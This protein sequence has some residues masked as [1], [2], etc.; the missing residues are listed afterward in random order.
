MLRHIAILALIVTTACAT[1]LPQPAAAAFETRATSAYLYD[2]T[3]DT[4]LFEKNADVPLPPASM[5]KLM[6]LY[7]LFD[8][9]RDGRVTLDT[10]FGVS[11][12]ARLMGGS[13][14]FLDE[15]DRPT[16]ESLIKGIIVQSGNDACIVVAE[17][18]A[19]SEDA[20]ARQMNARGPEIGL[21][22]STF[23]NASGWPDPNHR[24]SMHDLAVLASRLITDFPE[25][26]GYFALE[27]YD[28]DGRSPSN[29]FNRN[30]VLGLDMGADG[31]K[32]GHTMEAGY[33]LVGS[34]MQGDR[35][36][37]FVFSGL[38]T[39]AER[40]Q[41]AESF[42]NWGFRQFLSRDVAKKGDTITQAPVW[43]GSQ[44]QINLITESDIRLLVP[45]IGQDTLET[46]VEYATPL[47][48]PIAAGTKVGELVITARDMP[49]KRIDLVS[50]R[51]VAYGG[52]IPRI[53]ASAN[54]LFDKAMGQVQTLME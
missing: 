45:A 30:P 42:I 27:E 28:F 24:M 20:F 52:F 4:V 32:T 43:L 21:K 2:V 47:E 13:T 18:L 50:D 48:A 33:G 3:T 19:G 26:Y 7:M 9:L 35:R 49:E 6:T 25:Y 31:L 53:R 8:A 22:N 54:V 10:T 17:G 36:I 12:K 1:A 16:V 29:R 23:A 46:R 38:E 14:M 40:R 41:E 15:T 37:V 39:D 5:S 11:T 51:D 34:A 44:Q